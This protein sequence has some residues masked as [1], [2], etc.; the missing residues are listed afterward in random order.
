MMARRA[1]V[2]IRDK[3]RENVIVYLCIDLSPGEVGMWR[4]RWSGYWRPGR[5][6]RHVIARIVFVM[7]SVMVLM[8]LVRLAR[9][10][11]DV[12]ELQHRQLA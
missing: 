3:V 9:G 6:P 8:I 7:M 12:V 5:G 1:R 11:G 4:Q 10:Q 2:L